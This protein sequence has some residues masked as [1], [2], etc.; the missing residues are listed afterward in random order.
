MDI[1]S[2]EDLPCVSLL[3]GNLPESR[4]EELV[5]GI[6][7][8]YNI[9]EYDTLVVYN[10]TVDSARDIKEFSETEPL[11][12]VK[13]IVVHITSSSRAQAAL[14]TLLENPPSRIK[15]LIF[16]E[17]HILSTL[18]SRSQL[19]S[20]SFKESS[21]KQDKAIVVDVLKAAKM[22]DEVKLD[23]CLKSWDDN[24]QALLFQWAMET[25]LSKPTI[26]SLEE[27]SQTTLP[28]GFADSVIM[29]L[30]ILDSARPKLSA[31]SIFSSYVENR[32]H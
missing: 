15:F 18:E 6:T 11:G 23:S 13:L 28:G 14:L 10:L 22:L 3:K 8:K 29:A 5:Q 32:R 25:K 2:V 9:L 19:F 1:L 12:R 21:S 31:K 16:G 17:G 27:L 26:F 30:S 24:C 4:K 7:Q 20:T